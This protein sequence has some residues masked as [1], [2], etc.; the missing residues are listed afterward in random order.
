MTSHLSQWILAA[1]LLACLASFAWAMRAFFVQPAGATKGMRITVACGTISVILHISAIAL[2]QR[3]PFERAAAASA[4][5][6]AALTLFWW[7]VS[8]NRRKALS[9]I[10]SPDLPVHIVI[11]GPYR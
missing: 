8:T 2:A 10:F 11:E 7:A 9:A 3:V 4:L 6:A 5:Y 1:L